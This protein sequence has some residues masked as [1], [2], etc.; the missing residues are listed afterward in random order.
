MTRHARERARREGDHP[1]RILILSADMGEGH[2]ATGR[3]LEQAAGM[4]WPDC[5]IRWL[6]TL[7]VMGT[8][9]GPL[10]RAIYVGNVNTT[11]WLYEFFYDSLWRMRWFARASKRFVGSWCGRRLHKRIRAFDPDLILSTYPLGSAGLDWLRK[12]RRLDVPVGAWVSDFAPHPFWVYDDLDM[13]FV[14]HATAVDPAVRCTPEARVAVAAPP[15]VDSFGPGDRG[16]ARDRLGLPRERFVA[17]VSCG[18]FGFGDVADATRELLD[19]DPNV[20]PVVAC[21]RNEELRE[22]VAAVDPDRVVALGWTDDMPSLTVAADVVVTNAGGA[23]SLEALACG[24]AVLMYR[25]IAAHGKA[26]AALMAEAG[27]AE[28]TGRGELTAAV[29]RL[30]GEPETLAT[31][32]KR[33]HAHA[34]TR[35]V[36]D[37]LGD[38]AGTTPRQLP[39]RLRPADAMF[40][41]VATPQVPQQVGAVLVF[42]RKP[43]GSSISVDDAAWLLTAAPRSTGHLLRGS[44]WRP[45]AWQSDERV[46]LGAIVDE[47]TAADLPHAMDDFFSTAVSEDRL[48]YG[49][50]VHG[51]PGDQSALMFKLHH[52]LSDGM[53]VIASLV[54]KSR[55]EQYVLPE[56]MPAAKRTPSEHATLAVRHTK[57][58]LG[59]LLRLARGGPA[60]R[61]PLAGP[62][63]GPGRHHGLADFP[64]RRIAIAARSFGVGR[65]DFLLAVLAEALYRKTSSGEKVRAVV[66]RSTR[67]TTTLRMAGNYTGAASVDLPTGAM[68]FAQRA[69]SSKAELRGQLESGAPQTAELVL[70][71]IGLAP[72]WLHARLARMLYGSTWFNVITS[73][74]PGEQRPVM[75]D[76]AQLPVVYPVLALA[77][78][79]GIS[80]GMMTWRGRVTVCLSAS[81]E[82]AATADEVMAEV[83]AIVDEVAEP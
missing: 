83:H 32:E 82:L 20:V 77:P 75:L 40:L 24:R 9:V 22:R 1:E 66:T 4:Q 44:A 42:D 53:V 63:S 30:L 41:H 36:A 2:N 50:V 57:L 21:G 46:D 29:R 33:A 5:E 43:D 13:H 64:A 74:L 73:M 26:N 12:H 76:G 69:R 35:T 16:A 71:L 65:T 25:P 78:G 3:A 31:M 34:T 23:S 49:R 37:D 47:T 61:S 10:F 59:G 51:L 27:L 62:V 18:A 54:A 38:L 79:V 52:A 72:P 28:V 81:P 60:P 14:M 55:G 67:D 7:D 6:D 39:Q 48:C 15:V 19:A 70:Y 8:G 56:R 17:L 58:V 68:P 80:V 45:P 11:P